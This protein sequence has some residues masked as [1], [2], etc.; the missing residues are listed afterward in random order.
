MPTVASMSEGE[1]PLRLAAATGNPR[2]VAQVGLTAPGLCQE[3]GLGPE[4]N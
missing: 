3:P 4:H 2:C 1:H